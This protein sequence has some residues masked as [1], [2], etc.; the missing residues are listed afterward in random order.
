VVRA[1]PGLSSLLALL[2][3][4]VSVAACQPTAEAREREARLRLDAFLTAVRDG[5]NG[6]GW[7]LL[8]ED[9]RSAYPGGADAWINALKA[10][11]TGDLSWTILDVDGD[12]FV[13]C[14]NVDFGRDHAVVP[15]TFYDDQLPGPARIAASLS[16]GP[17]HMCVTVGPFPWDT[18]IHGVG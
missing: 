9:V 6:F 16:R 10:S 17:F 7:N 3:V 1:G 13:A 8:R 18:G 2:L 12:D 15:F 14:A 5:T 11:G 4:V